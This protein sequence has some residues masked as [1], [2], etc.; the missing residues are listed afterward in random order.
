MVARAAL[1]AVFA[2]LL[3]LF[4]WP[5]V[6][7]ASTAAPDPVEEAVR[8]L[9]VRELGADAAGKRIELS[10]GQLDARVQLAPCAKAEPFVP[11]G[12]RLWGRTQV[13]IRCTSGASWMVRLPVHVQVY[14]PAAVATQP[15]AAGAIMS[16]GDF[17]VEE[18]E[19]TREQ[20]PLVGDPAAL[21]GKQLTR[22]IAAG[23]AVR[24]DAYRI[25]P[26]INPGDPVQIIVT[27]QGFTL[28][29]TGVAL[30]AASEGQVL[31]ARTESGRVVSGTL[32]ERTLELRL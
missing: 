19:L 15:L 27:G 24:N 9:V 28:S 22:P 10:I 4:A 23:Q 7:L 11:P 12:T 5:G 25:P 20:T 32:R 31:R 21:A 26:T 8:R 16:P 13:G 6:C 17:R 14:G 29:G 3:G 2:A 1:R 30:I 18:V